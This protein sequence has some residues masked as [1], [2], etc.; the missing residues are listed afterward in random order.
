MEDKTYKQHHQNSLYGD[1]FEAH[2]KRFGV[3]YTPDWIVDLILAK[4]LEGGLEWK[5]IADPSCGEGAFLK[6]IV[7]RICAEASRVKNKDGYL[8]TLSHLTGFD[9]DQYALNQCRRELS[10]RVAG[11]FNEEIN[12]RL[13]RMDMMNKSKW[14]DMCNGFDVVV[15]NPPYVRIQHLEREG[16]ARMAQGEWKNLQGCTDLYMLFIEVGLELLKDE[17]LLGFITPNSWFRSNAGSLLRNYLRAT[18]GIVEIIDFGSWQVFPHVTTYTAISF[19]RKHG[20]TD[21]KIPVRRCVAMNKEPILENGY[22]IRSDDPLWFVADD[23]THQL[24]QKSRHNSLSLKDVADIHV[25]I[26]TL[27]D[28]VFIL[29][30]IE[31]LSHSVVCLDPFR[32]RKKI[33]LEKDAVKLIYKASVMQAGKDTKKRVAIYPYD[34]RG[35]LITEVLLQQLYPKTYKWLQRHRASLMRRDKGRI[36]PAKWY[37]YGRDVSIIKA[38]GRKILT[39]GMNREPNFQLCQDE[40]SLFYSGYCIKPFDGVNIRLLLKELNGE[41]ML[42]YIRTVSRPYR[43]NWF[44]YAKS[45][46]QHFPVPL[47][48]RE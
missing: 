33:E 46:I 7:A 19:L 16:R 26:Q 20:E 22:N 5:R 48:V 43:D 42:H 41:Y 23:A 10:N 15:G 27:S 37:G 38:L 1:L 21:L 30:V 18:H 9:I 32:L 13:H 3:V 31:E 17:G 12:W 45:F 11:T 40:D 6:R 4:T 25:G 39:S 24:V 35:H 8:F 2:K 44:S 34:E 14:H 47:S 28:A 36:K 29:E